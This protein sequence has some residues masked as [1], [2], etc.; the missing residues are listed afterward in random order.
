MATVDKPQNVNCLEV[1]AMPRNPTAA[2]FPGKAV[3]VGPLGL[4]LGVGVES[5]W[6]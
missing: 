1:S 2:P 5:E 6:A 4:V 3:T